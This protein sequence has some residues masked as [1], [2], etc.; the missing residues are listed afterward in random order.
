M[1]DIRANANLTH[2]RP[3]AWHARRDGAEADA[4]LLDEFFSLGAT[5]GN[6]LRRRLGPGGAD[7]RNVRVDVATRTW[8]TLARD[9]P[10]YNATAFRERMALQRNVQVRSYGSA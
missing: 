1:Y 7:M 2:I 4:D 6:L 3:P 9:Y 10:T 8:V 5:S